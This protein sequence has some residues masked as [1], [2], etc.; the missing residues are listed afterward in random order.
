M[1]DSMPVGVASPRPVATRDFDGLFKPLLEAHPRD[2]LHPLC[3]ARL[4]G[5]AMVLEHPDR[6]A[7]AT[8]CSGPWGG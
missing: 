3:G 1:S 5:R 4:D 6:A 7:A 8:S 2:A